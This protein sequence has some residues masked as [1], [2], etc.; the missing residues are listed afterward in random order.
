MIERPCLK[1]LPTLSRMSPTLVR[2]P[3]HSDAWA[4]EEKYDGWRLRRL[5]TGLRAVPLLR[6]A[7]RW[8]R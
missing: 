1:A 6:R 4:Y 3:F 2:E 8:F 5:D 7:E